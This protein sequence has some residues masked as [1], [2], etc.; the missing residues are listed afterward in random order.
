MEALSSTHPAGPMESITKNCQSIAALRDG[1]NVVLMIAPPATVA[2][3][4]YERGA[5]ATELTA[6]R[7]ATPEFDEMAV[8]VEVTHL[9]SPDLRPTRVHHPRHQSWFG[10]RQMPVVM[11]VADLDLLSHP[12]EVEHPHGW[13]DPRARTRHGRRGR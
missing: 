8:A 2:V 11:V 1:S 6:L 10:A 12:P 4:T 13:T 7:L 5:M 9:R 3:L